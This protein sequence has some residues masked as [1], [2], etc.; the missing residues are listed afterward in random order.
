V[1][2]GGPALG[3]LTLGQV[4]A[5]GVVPAGREQVA[6][7]SGVSVDPAEL[8]WVDV[9]A[10]GDG[11]SFALCDP[12]AVS[13]V[14]PKGQRWPLILSAA[15]SQTLSPERWKALRGGSSGCIS[16][17]SAPSTGPATMTISASRRGR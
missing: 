16:S 3:F 13:G 9:T 1:P 10:P 12:V 6:R 5:D 17:I 14:A 2:E 8:T 11:A 4:G 15:F 7:R